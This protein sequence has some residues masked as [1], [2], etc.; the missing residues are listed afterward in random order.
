MHHFILPTTK[1]KLSRRHVVNLLTGSGM[2]VARWATISTHWL[3]SWKH[4]QGDTTDNSYN[5]ITA[6][7]LPVLLPLPANLRTSCHEGLASRPL[8]T[9]TTIPGIRAATIVNCYQVIWAGNHHRLLWAMV[10]SYHGCSYRPPVWASL[11][12]SSRSV[13][14]SHLA[15]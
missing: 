10:L 1:D 12:Q 11:T 9:I 2:V 14:I 6:R 15:R 7:R 5:I 13:R 8:H 3:M 4:P